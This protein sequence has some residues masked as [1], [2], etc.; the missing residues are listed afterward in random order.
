MNP[1][2]N[3]EIKNFKSIRHV[4]I[5]DCRRINVFVGY[6]N[7][8]KSNI[9]E[10]LGLYSSF[11]LIGEQ[12]NFND[13]C[14][15]KRLSEVFFNKEYRNPVSVNINDSL[16]LELK[17]DSNNDLDIRI[18]NVGEVVN[19]ASVAIFSAKVPGQNYRYNYDGPIN[20]TAF[21]KVLQAVRKY[22]FKADSANNQKKPLA[23]SV[24]YG[25]NLLEVLHND[26]IL[27]K[28]IAG[29]F[30]DYGQR[31]VIDDDEIS[32]FKYL[33]DDT[34]VRIPYHLVSDTLRRLIF[35]KA[36]IYSNKTSVLLFEEPE[37][38]M[39]PPYISKFTADVMYDKG[40]NQFFMTTH[41]P[42]VINDFMENLKKEDYSIYV[43][44]Y[45]K[46]SGETVVRKLT[47][48]ELHEIYQYGTDLYLNLENYLFYEQQ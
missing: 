38:H 11:R 39:F 44:G 7:V 45:K 1:I 25:A 24:P 41:S 40:D 14:R 6:P 8:G 27:R 28:D 31:L 15:V 47:D 3:I 13:I 19:N 42:F 5:D 4:K 37:A 17:L 35:Y 10:A 48:E 32:F 9:L 26:S 12:F 36:A 43:T 46:E 18:G 33:I 29:L 34:I 23:L 16:W 21:M 30:E 22:Q 20:E 2:K